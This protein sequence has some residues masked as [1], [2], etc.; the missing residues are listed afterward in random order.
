MASKGVMSQ[1]LSSVKGVCRANRPSVPM[2]EPPVTSRFSR[3]MGLRPSWT[4][5]QAHAMPVPPAPTMAMSHSS[6]SVGS[7]TSS[8][9]QTSL[10]SAMI[11]ASAGLAASAEAP[12]TAA[13]ATAAPATKLRRDMVM[14]DMRIPP[15]GQTTERPPR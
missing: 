11:F 12:A 10:D 6:V 5:W 8:R 13:P 4:A 9:F 7:P 14:S 1:P 15:Y 2:N 3:T